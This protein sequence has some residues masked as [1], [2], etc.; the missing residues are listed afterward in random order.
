M[1]LTFQ[2]QQA[3]KPISQNNKNKFD[4]LLSEVE[5]CELRDLLG[6]ALL[7]DL[8]TNPT[9]A[10]NLK[11]L[12]GDSFDYCGNTIAHKGLRF[13]LAYLIHSKY[14]GE[15]YLTDTFSGIVK[16]KTEQSEP[17]T[18]GEIRRLQ[19]GSRKIALS[20]FEIIKE[21]LNSKSET[22]TK[23]ACSEYKKPFT[24]RIYGIRKTAN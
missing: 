12:N 16:K 10:N 1:L 24:P 4:Q 19:E 9:N 11:L 2:Q 23:W 13:V 22:F 17:A 5:N 14:I 15:V 7:Q 21:Y 20:E 8:Q 3:Y 18:E 6:V